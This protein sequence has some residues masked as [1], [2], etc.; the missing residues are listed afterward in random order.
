MDFVANLYVLIENF[1]VAELKFSIKTMYFQR[2]DRITD[3]I[4]F[5]NI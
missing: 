4:I 1:E 3:I 2:I 5:W